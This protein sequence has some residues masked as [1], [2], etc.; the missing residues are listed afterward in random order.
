MIKESEVSN[1]Y[2]GAVKPPVRRA[3]NRE[4]GHMENVLYAAESPSQRYIISRTG[5]PIKRFFYSL[6]LGSDP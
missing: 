2:T 6:S 5:M 4:S 1:G 3:G